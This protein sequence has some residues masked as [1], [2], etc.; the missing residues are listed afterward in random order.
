MPTLPVCNICRDGGEVGFLA[1][2]NIIF[3]PAMMNVTCGEVQEMGRNNE[4]DDNQCDTA[5]AAAAAQN[6]CECTGQVFPTV[7]PTP[8]PTP[9][10]SIQHHSEVIDTPLYNP[11]PCAIVHPIVFFQQSQHKFPLPVPLQVSSIESNRYNDL[12]PICN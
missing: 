1:L 3:M 4:L 11:N 9:G 2:D 7:A 5:Q 8:N 6:R 12:D 10:K